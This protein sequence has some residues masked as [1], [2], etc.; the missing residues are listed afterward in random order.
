MTSFRDWLK[1]QKGRKDDTGKFAR[2][3]FYVN[4]AV[5]F[6]SNAVT[7]DVL[8]SH[9]SG[10]CGVRDGGVERFEVIYKEYVMSLS[11]KD[12]EEP[13]LCACGCGEGVPKWNKYVDGHQ[14]KHKQHV[15]RYRDML[16]SKPTGA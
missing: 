8:W 6:T 7:C 5:E 14:V 12:T 16:L 1:E 11:K 3:V 4:N 10:A 9:L 13:K 15:R 2:Q